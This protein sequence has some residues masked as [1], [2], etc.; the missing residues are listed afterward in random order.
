MTLGFMTHF[1]NGTPTDFVEKIWTGLIYFGGENE[2]HYQDINQEKFRLCLFSK[3]HTIRKKGKRPWNV[4]DKI[5]MVV[6]NR[7]KNRHQF[8]PTLQVTKISTI[9]ISYE[10][11]DNQYKKV[12]IKI[13]GSNFISVYVNQDGHLFQNGRNDSINIMSLLQLSI[14]DG[15]STINGFLKWFN[16]D[17]E[18]Q[19][20]YWLPL[21]AELEPYQREL[22]TT[23]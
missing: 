5:H 9:S 2:S 21:S 12:S 19:I 13:D 17:F 23:H 10:T 7:T 15:F 18:G 22:K 20:I 1:P 6:N 4:G 16:S 11:I 8:A 3:I 14:N